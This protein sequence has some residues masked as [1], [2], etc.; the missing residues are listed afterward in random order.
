VGRPMYWRDKLAF[1][2]FFLKRKKVLF[3]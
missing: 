2:F 1:G 3:Y